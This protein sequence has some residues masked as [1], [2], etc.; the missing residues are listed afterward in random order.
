MPLIVDSREVERMAEEL[1]TFTGETV[2]EAVANALKE[3]LS[4]ERRK[5]HRTAGL[6]VQMV[7]IGRECSALPLLDTRTS[8]AI[9]GY[10]EEG[11]PG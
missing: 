2:M 11:V 8:D 6:A 4:S 9:M 7:Q 1:T 3:R 10:N 5:R